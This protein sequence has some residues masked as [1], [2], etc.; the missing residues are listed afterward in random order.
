MSDEGTRPLKPNF[1]IRFCAQVSPEPSPQR[2]SRDECARSQHTCIRYSSSSAI[3]LKS[4]TQ[5]SPT[6]KRQMLS[7]D[8]PS[9]LSNVSAEILQKASPL[10]RFSWHARFSSRI[11][12]EVVASSCKTDEFPGGR[13]YSLPP[14]ASGRL[15]K[16]HIEKMKWSMAVEEQDER[17]KDSSTLRQQVC[18]CPGMSCTGTASAA[19]VHINTSAPPSLA[20]APAGSAVRIGVGRNG[21]D[22]DDD[23]HLGDGRYDLDSEPSRGAM[24]GGSSSQLSRQIYPSSPPSRTHIT[25]GR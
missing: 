23:D 16:R 2:L 10:R 25:P 12:K 13:R 15:S 3:S 7:V 19:T 21:V 4:G 18:Q 24:S 5:S 22:H 9:E 14:P 11:S 6:S 1:T 8:V 20:V 17:L